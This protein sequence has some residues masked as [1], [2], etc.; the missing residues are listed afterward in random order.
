MTNERIEILIETLE[1]RRKMFLR[2]LT[3]KF[4]PKKIKVGEREWC[5]KLMEAYTENPKEYFSFHAVVLDP[6]A[7]A[8]VPCMAWLAGKK[9]SFLI[10][11]TGKYPYPILSDGTHFTLSCR[12][13]PNIYRQFRQS[14]RFIF[15]RQQ[16]EDFS[17][18]YYLTGT[19][20]FSKEFSRKINET[21]DHFEGQRHRYNFMK[22][23]KKNKAK[24]DGEDFDASDLE[25]LFDFD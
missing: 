2:R 7:I 15:S 17:R 22:I 21:S 10:G 23:F 5:R 3:K 18:M 19:W 14:P 16:L 8:D 9:G 1:S 6:I 25:K 11:G 12:D 24:D 13:N 4:N 20:P